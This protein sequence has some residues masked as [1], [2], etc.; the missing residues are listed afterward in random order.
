MR[1]ISA[2]NPEALD[3]IC[4]D[5][6]SRFKDG[7]IA[8]LSGVLGAGKTEFVKRF[9]LA[10]GVTEVAS[11]SF[12]IMHEYAPNLRH[13][14]LYRVGSETFFARGLQETLESGWNFIEWA[15]EAIEN[16]LK[17]NAIAY[18]KIAIEL[19]GDLRLISIY[20]E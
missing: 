4:A 12:G 13:F 15:D 6:L 1:Q 7:T 16:Y 19:R 2:A 8:L 9:A 20:D 5:L 11:P 3:P 17:K 18:I 10:L 14:D